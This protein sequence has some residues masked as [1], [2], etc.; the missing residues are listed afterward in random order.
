MA[1]AVWEYFMKKTVSFSFAADQY[2]LLFGL[3]I[4]K[5]DSGAFSC[6]IS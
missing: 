2:G 1:V 3:L 6:K 5:L 4:V